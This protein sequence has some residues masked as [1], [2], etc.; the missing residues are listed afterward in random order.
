VYALGIRE[1]GEATAV[2]LVRHFGTLESIMQISEEELQNAPE[3]GLVAA[4]HMV[5]FFAQPHN[6]EISTHLI[7]SDIIWSDIQPD[8]GNKRPYSNTYVIT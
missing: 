4:Q 8:T 5:T 7:E 2:S 3:M 6:K 1:V